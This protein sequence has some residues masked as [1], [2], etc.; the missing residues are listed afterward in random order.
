MLAIIS[1]H[2]LKV[3]HPSRHIYFII[4]LE[5]LHSKGIGHL[6][7][8]TENI[9]L[10]KDFNLILGDFGFSRETKDLKTG[11]H[12]CLATRESIGS[13]EYSPPEVTNKLKESYFAEEADLFASACILFLLV[14][15]SAPF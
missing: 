8:K 2:S 14:M 12:L 11:A 15:K 3:I 7:I 10:D 9:L 4:G 5:Y 1:I 6:D 13:P